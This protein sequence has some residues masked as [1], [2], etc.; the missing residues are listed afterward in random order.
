MDT[1]IT[2]TDI[3]VAKLETT[4]DNIEQDIVELKQDIK[5]V[6]G[7]VT[8]G[9]TAIMEKLTSMTKDTNDQHSDILHRMD[10][11]DRRINGR[12]SAL[13]RWKYWV[14]GAA[15]VAAWLISNLPVANF[16]A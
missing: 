1:I 6:H 14:I 5:V 10:A 2:N 4:V 12:V 11:M 16:F 8:D 15:V 7:R 13:E 3:K 9:N